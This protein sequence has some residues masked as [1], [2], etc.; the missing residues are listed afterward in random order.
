MFSGN[1]LNDQKKIGLGLTGGGILFTILGMLLLFDRGFIAL[2]NLM[3]LAGLSITIGLHSTITFF[4]RKKNRKGSAFYLGGCCVVVYGWPMIGLIIE[5]YGFFL[6]F[7]EFFPTVLQFLRRVPFLNKTLDLPIFKKIFNHLQKM[8]GLP[9][10]QSDAE[11]GVGR[12]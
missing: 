7:C 3:F 8:G 12:R 5:A 10:T 9:R 11:F 6:L 1:W 4:L 2:G